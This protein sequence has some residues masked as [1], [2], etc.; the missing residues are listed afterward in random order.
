M[1]RI[2]ESKTKIGE[3]VNL[4]FQITQHLREEE[5][6]QSLIKYFKCGYIEKDKSGNRN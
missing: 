1:V 2:T 3:S 5:L 6:M 4:V